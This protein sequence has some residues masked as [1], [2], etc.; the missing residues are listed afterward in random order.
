LGGEKSWGNIED[1][2][3]GCE[4]YLRGCS[5]MGRFLREGFCGIFGQRLLKMASSFLV[6]GL[7]SHVEWF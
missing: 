4:W 7:R 1:I 3:L 5:F 6:I 2:G